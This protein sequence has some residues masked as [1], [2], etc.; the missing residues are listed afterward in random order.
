[1]T[2]RLKDLTGQQFGHWTVLSYIGPAPGSMMW[3]CR[4]QC[5]V[6]RAVSAG[7]MKAGKSISCGCIQAKTTSQR[8]FKHGQSSH[9]IYTSWAG[10]KSRCLNENDVDFSHYGGRGIRVCDRWLEDFWHFWSDMAAE[11]RPGLSVERKDVN[12]N[13]EPKNCCWATQS[14]QMRNTRRTIMLDTPWGKMSVT[15]AAEKAGI[16]PAILRQRI[17]KGFML[18]RLFEKGD[19]RQKY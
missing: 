17:Y 16:K 6:E 2:S 3:L 18:D 15:D 11:W 9:P 10:L 7:N 4:C 14:R 8:L 19:G 1:M 13:Y 5:G 12:G